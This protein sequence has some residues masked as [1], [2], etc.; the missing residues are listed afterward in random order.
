MAD[1]AFLSA[2]DDNTTGGDAG[3]PGSGSDVG[4]GTGL[5]GTGD[6]DNTA[7]ATG[8]T[9]G[10][11][12]P[13]RRSVRFL[14]ALFAEG[15]DTRLNVCVRPGPQQPFAG[16]LL[17]TPIAF[18]EVSPYVELEPSTGAAVR[19]IDRSAT[20]C[21]TSVDEEDA[22][23]DFDGDPP[24]AYVVR[25]SSNEMAPSEPITI[26]IE[27]HIISTTNPSRLYARFFHAGTELGNLNIK[28]NDCAVPFSAFEQV[29]YSTLG[30]S[31]NDQTTFFSSSVTL[32]SD[33]FTTDIVLCTFDGASFTEI[34][35][36]PNFRL[37]GGEVAFTALTGDGST[38]APYRVLRCL[39]R[40]PS[41]CEFMA[42]ELPS[43]R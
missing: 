29:E 28:Q 2:C 10:N 7:T 42:T 32:G 19:W 38:A 34:L 23:I 12:G 11:V 22:V 8:G 13:L 40:D 4:S 24:P 3:S 41:P 31:P 30:F 27:D 33:H 5:S 9:G 25:L 43:A 39:E 37:N 21:E 1:G 17:D 20:D 15:T 16:P 35:T 26:S 36:I 18:G 6:D 14:N